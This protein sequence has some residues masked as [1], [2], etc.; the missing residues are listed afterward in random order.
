VPFAD[1]G[2]TPVF[3]T[4]LYPFENGLK[5][6]SYGGLCPN[7]E[8]VSQA[9]SRAAAQRALWRL[10]QVARPILLHTPANWKYRASGG[11]TYSGTHSVPI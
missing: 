5:A 1:D 9:C 6:I 10:L 8:A 7:A 11:V 3:G 2:Q 4:A